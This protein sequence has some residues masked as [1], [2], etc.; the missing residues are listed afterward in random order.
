[1]SKKIVKKHNKNRTTKNEKMELYRVVKVFSALLILVEESH[2][3]RENEGEEDGVVVF[4]FIDNVTINNVYFDTVISF[5]FSLLC[6]VRYFRTL[7]SPMK[8]FHAF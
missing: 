8:H 2:K 7:S 3:S 6:F 5:Y 1:M 4:I